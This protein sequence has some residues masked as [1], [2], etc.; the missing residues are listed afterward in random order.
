[1]MSEDTCGVLG[2]PKVQLETKQP[3]ILALSLA[4]FAQHIKD[5]LDAVFQHIKD[6]IDARNMLFSSISNQHMT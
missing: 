4:T 5:A 6:A 2:R 1:M 3:T